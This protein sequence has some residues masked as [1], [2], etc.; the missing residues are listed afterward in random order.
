MEDE[1]ADAGEGYNKR[2]ATAEESGL[3]NNGGVHLPQVSDLQQVV[4]RRIAR[5]GG[6]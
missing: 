1:G 6:R 5:G 3:G 4:R 2:I